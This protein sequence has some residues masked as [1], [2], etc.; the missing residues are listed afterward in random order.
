MGVPLTLLAAPDDAQ[1]LVIEAGASVPGEIAALRAI[2][3]PTIAVVTNVGYA[4]VGG[5]GSLEA[6]LAE[7][8][9]L[10]DAA[11]LAVVGTEPPALA[12]EAR[13]GAR[14]D[15]CDPAPERGADTLEIA[16]LVG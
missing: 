14:V 8:A 2:I 12:A 15:D 3:E 13:R 4:H 5:F 7:K 10:C 6:V 16:N 9:S 11:P 1:A